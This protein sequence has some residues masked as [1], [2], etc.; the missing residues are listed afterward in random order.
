[1]TTQR[2]ATPAPHP[3]DLD[4]VY[5]L[6][7]R[8]DI[9]PSEVE[10]AARS[11]VEVTVL[12]NRAALHVAH[13]GEGAGF[14]LTS[15]APS[16]TS[17]VRRALPAF[18]A[19][20]ALMLGGALAASLPVASIGAVATAVGVGLGVR[21]HQ[22][23]DAAVQ[24]PGRFVVAEEMLGA[25]E[26]PVIVRE[27]DGTRF[28][29]PR[30]AAGEVEIDGEKR[31]VEQ[32]LAQGHARASQ[33]CDGAIEVAMVPGGRYRM[34]LAGLTVIA[35]VVR[36]GRR[37]GA[38]VGRDRALRSAGAGSL[39]LAVAMLGVLRLASTDES[40]LLSATDPD[41]ALSDL[42][43]FIARQEARPEVPPPAEAAAAEPAARD[44][45]AHS[46]PAGA[47]G[48][49]DTAD[50]HHRYEI[51]RT[52]EPPHLT[53]RTAREQV[54]ERGV[55]A[56][57][58]GTRPMSAD[59]S[60]GI[61]SPFGQVTEAGDA[62]RSHHGNLTGDV[63]GDAFGYNGLDGVGPGWGGGGDHEGTVGTG[64]LNTVGRSAGCPEG[65][66]C[67]YGQNRG[68]L[69]DT[70]TH[71][72]RVTPSRPEV[73]GISPEVIRRVVL[74]NIGQVNHCYEQGLATNSA[75]AGRVSVQFVI[76][77]SGSVISAHVVSESLGV[78]AVSTCIAAAVQR[79]SF[80]LPADSGAITVT[81]PFSLIPADG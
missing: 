52:N 15:R 48:R 10:D 33:V 65:E 8:A 9:D 58:G 66:D 41:A 63:A 7:K 20:G 75:L 72:P 46:G 77:P 56:A 67:R 32:L 22:R 60:S 38:G 34:E 26:L 5:Q 61:V 70:G 62:D 31:G 71:G 44:G 28:I 57:L 29:V 1:M 68:R 19:G 73:S 12:W 36:A 11:A 39:A 23:N 25:D 43:A 18:G 79:W 49:P 35:K 78:P 54:S 14:T 81:Y 27:G 2:H 74:R 37:T 24:D 45:A 80:Q 50:T 42:R 55:F 4:A 47:M 6:V 59:G 13:L 53:N 30:G 40:G 76:S 69:H 64:T 16:L 21:A 51:R 17:V 3:S